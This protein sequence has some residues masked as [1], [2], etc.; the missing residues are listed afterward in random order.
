MFRFTVCVSII[1][2]ITRFAT[3]SVTRPGIWVIP[4]AKPPY[5]II[6]AIV[7]PARGMTQ[8]VIRLYDGPAPGSEAWDWEEQDFGS[9]VFNT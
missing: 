5:K 2:K 1:E 3:Y 4:A 8:E 9:V 6:P 7:Y